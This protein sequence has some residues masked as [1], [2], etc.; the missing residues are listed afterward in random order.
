MSEDLVRAVARSICEAD[1]AG[2]VD[3]IFA[4]TEH[5]GDCLLAERPDTYTCAKCQAENYTEI[6]QAALTAIEQAGYTLVPNADLELIKSSLDQVRDEQTETL[7]LI[8]AVFPLK[9]KKTP[10][11]A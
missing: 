3:M 11:P 1:D 2:N 5:H 7:A 8:S 6:A 4:E 10:G 9:P